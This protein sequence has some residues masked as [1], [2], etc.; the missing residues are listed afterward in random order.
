MREQLNVNYAQLKQDKYKAQAHM[1]LLENTKNRLNKS[2]ALIVKQKNK[3]NDLTMSKDLHVFTR[4]DSAKENQ[5]E[6]MSKSCNIYRNRPEKILAD[7]KLEF[8]EEPQMKNDI[9]RSVISLSECVKPIEPHE[10]SPINF[11]ESP[12]HTH[13]IT[14]YKI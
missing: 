11:D 3:I 7:L 1:K 14:P 13:D 9:L 6:N 5:H 4:K 2:S 10:D 8:I 12:K